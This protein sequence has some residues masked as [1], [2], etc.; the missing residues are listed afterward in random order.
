M[1]HL[2]NAITRKV[3]G[4][5][6]KKVTMNKK[7]TNRIKKAHSLATNFFMATIRFLFTDLVSFWKILVLLCLNSSLRS[8]ANFWNSPP[9][10]NCHHCVHMT[11][12]SAYRFL[13]S[14][15]LLLLWQCTLIRSC[16]HKIFYDGCNTCSCCE[17]SCMY[18][19][20]YCLNRQRIWVENVENLH[21]NFKMTTTTNHSSS[22]WV[23]QN[24]SRV[25]VVLSLDDDTSVQKSASF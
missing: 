16:D 9:E 25:S 11:R 20:A 22:F 4:R 12:S 1:T 18:T 10:H 3:S 17:D 24:A 19:L 8:L 15:F 7:W 13:F 6:L 14:C 21:P 2:T 5:Q 23:R